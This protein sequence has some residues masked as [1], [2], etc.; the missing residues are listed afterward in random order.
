VTH[1]DD[2]KTVDVSEPDALIDLGEVVRRVWAKVG[3]SKRWVGH[4]SD[5]ALKARCL[6]KPIIIYYAPELS[7]LVSL[8]HYRPKTLAMS[9]VLS[10]VGVESEPELG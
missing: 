3:Q 2:A 6:E 7:N 8:G 4:A 9:G 5:T 10:L 1:E